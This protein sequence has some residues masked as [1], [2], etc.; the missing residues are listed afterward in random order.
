MTIKTHPPVTILY[1][2]YQTTL[3]DLKQFTGEE[4]KKLYAEAVSKNAFIAGPG[5]WIYKGADG[6]PDTVFTLE[7]AVPVQGLTKPSGNF[8]L[9]ELPAF[10]AAVQIHE[11]SWERLAETYGQMIQQLNGKKMAL[12]NECRE[13][14]IN[15]DFQQPENNITEVQVGIE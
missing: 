10:K 5:Y 1:S 2:E 9:K 12:N 13:L 8:K 11:G 15:V 14:Y 4:V 6:N 7:I 3:K